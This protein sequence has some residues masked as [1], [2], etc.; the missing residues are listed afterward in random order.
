MNFIGRDAFEDAFLP[1]SRKG[2]GNAKA[3]AAQ[4]RCSSRTAEATRTQLNAFLYRVAS[5]LLDLLRIMAPQRTLQPEH[6]HNLAKIAALLRLPLTKA[7][8][9]QGQGRELMMG[10]HAGTVLPGSYFDP[11]NAVDAAS[12]REA[13]GVA[14][15]PVFAPAASSDGW[16]RYPMSSTFQPMLS[17]GC[18]CSSTSEAFMMDGGEAAVSRGWL[19][20][21]VFAALVHEYKTRCPAHDLRMGESAKSLIK[22]L[23]E[24]N[25]HA[26][27]FPKRGSALTSASIAKAAKTWELRF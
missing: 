9:Q 7:N 14:G 2:K 22:Q 17:G 12:Y 26:A 3:A 19:S 25:V 24:A 6:V 11:G 5:R 15:S 4:A 27:L 18:G 23:V 21:G 16:I 1:K 13:N 8:A 10:G 20:D